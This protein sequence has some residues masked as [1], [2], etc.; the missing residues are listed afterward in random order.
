MKFITAIILVI[1]T[2]YGLNAQYDIRI[3]DLEKTKSRGAD[4]AGVD[5]QGYIYATGY[6][7]F[8]FLLTTVITDWIKVINSSTGNF[9]IEQKMNK[10]DVAQ[11]G[12]RFEAFEFIEGRPIY[13]ATKRDERDNRFFYAI[14]LD[15]NLSLM[16]SPYKIGKKSNC[17][18]FF[19]SS[20]KGFLAGVDYFKSK[21]NRE[22]TFVSD[23]TCRGDDA[24]H[25]YAVT[26]NEVNN[27]LNEVEFTLPIAG[28]IDKSNFFVHNN[29]IYYSIGIRT[30]EN[31]QGKIFKQNVTRNYLYVINEFG[32]VE[33]ISIDFGKAEGA[34]EASFVVT[35]NQI[36]ISGQIVNTETNKLEGL[37]SAVIDESN[38]SLLN[39]EKHYF[40]QAFITRFWSSFEVNRTARRNNEP[41]F[42][43]NFILVDRYETDD[44]GAVYLYQKRI[45]RVVSRATQSVSGMVQYQTT[46]YYYYQE[47]IAA[48]TNS[49]G[50]LDWVELVPID[51][52]FIEYDPGPSFVS[53]QRDG[54]I[55]IIHSAN[56]PLIDAINKGGFVSSSGYSFRERRTGGVGITKIGASGK[57]NAEL[58]DFGGEMIYFNAQRVGL[59]HN[60][61]KFIL[62]SSRVGFFG[63]SKKT[64]LIQISF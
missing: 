57:T 27:V 47:V 37:F 2:L 31:V 46:T 23:L 6:R 33:D 24:L 21:V 38:N 10:R 36:I 22:R 40:D 54:N 61:N 28:D 5:Q 50:Y 52:V 7:R 14:E 9:V 11:L 17:S 51:D 42:S 12:Y 58:L 1:L 25:F 48:K 30:R 20:S 43:P 13:I 63:E 41:A 8:N 55:Y 19:A 53:A 16:G 29:K 59:M 35:D 45:V 26:I 4:F 64:K 60:E 34:S 56:Q 32:D 49:Q 15:R 44:G 18:G 62:L 3:Q 39:L